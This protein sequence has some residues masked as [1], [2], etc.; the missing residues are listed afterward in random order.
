MT[1]ILTL[2]HTFWRHDVFLLHERHGYVFDV[3]TYFLTSCRIFDV[4]YELVDV[5]MYFLHH[6]AC[7]IRHSLSTCQLNVL[8][9][10]LYI[11]SM[12]EKYN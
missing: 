9:H 6:G 3:M 1:N 11:Y 4:M 10:I 8:Y 5:M 2:L 12:R 7:D